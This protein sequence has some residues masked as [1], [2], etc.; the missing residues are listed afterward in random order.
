MCYRRKFKRAVGQRLTFTYTL[1]HHLL[2]CCFKVAFE[3]L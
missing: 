2:Q 1:S 3:M